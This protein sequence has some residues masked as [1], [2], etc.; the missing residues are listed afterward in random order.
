MKRKLG[1]LI[2]S[3]AMYTQAWAVDSF[4]VKDIRVEG[5]QR[6]SAGTVFNYLPVKIGDQID[7][8]RSAE[9]IRAL[10]KTGFFKDVRFERE[11]DVLVVFVH[12]RPAINSIDIKG[13][14]EIDKDS[15][16]K[17]LADIGFVEGRVFDSSILERVKSELERQYFSRGQYGVKIESTVT[18]L[19]R[20]RVAIEISVVEG[21][22]ARIHQINIIGNTVFD[23]ETLMDEM[24]SGTS[25]WFSFFTKDDQYSKQQLGADL[26]TIRSFYLDRGYINFNISSTQVSITPDKKDIYITINITEGEV[27]TVSEVKLAGDLILEESELLAL[28][29]SKPAEI[30]SRKKIT[31]STKSITDRLGN[32]GYA[33]ANIN[34]VPDINE[35][36]KT[37]VLTYFIDPGKRVYVHRINM[38][39]N[40]RTADEVIRREMRQMEGG[41]ISTE[42]VERSK[43]RL[44]RTDYFEEVSVETPPVAG[45]ADQ[46]D[47]NFK[48]SEKASGNLTAGVGF[49]QAQGLVLNASVSQDNFLGTG[50][51]LSFAFNTSDVNKTYSFGYVNPYYTIDGVSRGFNFY[52]RETD[53][54][55]ANVGNFVSNTAGADMS[56]G[57][58]INEFDGIYTSVGVETVELIT[59]STTPTEYLN[60]INQNGSDYTNLKLSGSWA[61][62]TR[63]K[64]IFPTSGV[65]Q[66]FT[67]EFSLGDMEFFK[68]NYR[69]TR[70]FPLTKKLTLGLNGELGYGDSYG[71]TTELPFYENYYAGGPGSVRGYQA[72]TLGPRATNTEP[73]GGNI[74]VLGNAEVIFPMP[75]MKKPPKS[76]RLTAFLDAGNVYGFGQDF[77]IGELRYSAGLSATWLSPFGALTFSLG[78]ALN[79]EAG[80]DT[81]VFQFQLGASL[82]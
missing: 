14:L 66:R 16:L 37:V 2:F 82:R 13:N 47:V 72:N 75:F 11:G 63:N 68:G 52:T 49:S 32:D 21:E 57:I 29:E 18:P 31:E 12:E 9:A 43:E 15:L 45:T 50:R 17:S 46:V 78:K 42:K 8:E 26:E 19:E 6:I 5:L 71:G 39:G 73:L 1:A 7:D 56:F 44:E 25:G 70:Y 23:D 79:N 53:A 34:T 64:S 3:C 36:N 30:F 40:T 22:P 77:D 67:M 76:L 27:Y 10:F 65:L 35:E 28:I 38:E 51:R 4:H 55:Q 24:E 69:H 60:F 54:G 48:V 74:K 62:D 80:D 61:H 33:F 20:N 41:W 81:E 58:P 59:T